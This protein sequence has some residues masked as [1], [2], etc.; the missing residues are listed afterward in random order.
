[1]DIIDFLMDD[2]VKMQKEMV[3]IRQ[4]IFH[5]N[6]TQRIRTLIERYELHESIEEEILFPKFE[7][8]LRSRSDA[9]L[10][11]CVDAHGEIWELFGKMVDCLNSRRCKGL[12]EAF[13]EFSASAEAHIRHEE[14]VLFPTIR[15][16]VDKQ[17]LKDLLEKARKR[18]GC[19]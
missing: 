1:M 19:D 2:H 12:Q 5:G 13:F 9:Q 7:D 3:A 14:R 15:E 16:Y 8:A 17:V 18:H 6:A 10:S 4:D 11:K